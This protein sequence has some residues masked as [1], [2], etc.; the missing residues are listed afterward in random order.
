MVYWR[1]PKSGKQKSKYFVLE[2][3]ARKF[4]RSKL[5]ELKALHE[6]N[7]SLKIKFLID[8]Y[9]ASRRWSEQSLK[10]TMY[11][12]K[13]LYLFL[14][15]IPAKKLNKGDIFQYS[16]KEV[17]RGVKKSTI[18]RRLTI[19]KA[20]LNFAVDIGKLELNPIEKVHQDRGIQKTF[21]PPSAMELTRMLE[22]APRH[23]RRTIMLGYYTGVRIGPSECFAIPWASCDLDRGSLR[24]LGAAKNRDMPYRDIPIAP[25]LLREMLC[26]KDWDQEKY[27]DIDQL[28]IVNYHGR[29][30]KT[31]ARSWRTTL[32]RAGIKRSLRPYDLRHAFATDC[33]DA[34]A[35][36]KAVSQVMGHAGIGTVLRSYQYVRDEQKR[37]SVNSLPALV[38]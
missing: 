8:E 22:V 18:S 23:I 33:L 29:A 36:I 27:G 25:T 2:S 31:I 5:K 13:T 30:L 10:Q 21:V 32:A 38:S 6:E 15:E 17:E 19:L 3:S 4:N 14:G 11:H 34:G 16:Q 20:A 37:K 28:Q 24:V 7:K 9:L 26:W 12:T 35:D 1:D